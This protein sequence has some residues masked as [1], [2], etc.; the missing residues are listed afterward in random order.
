MILEL[1][2]PLL[3][4]LSFCSI[5]RL[6]SLNQMLGA[7]CIAAYVLGAHSQDAIR[8]GQYDAVYA[9]ITLGLCF[10]VIYLARKASD[11]KA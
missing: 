3:L 11:T 8:Q 10:G 9:T 2:L 4:V 6:I 5:F 7:L 1:L